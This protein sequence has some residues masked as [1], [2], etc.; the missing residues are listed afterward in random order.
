MDREP[1]S[2]IIDKKGKAQPNLGDEAMVARSNN[3]TEAP[4]E[5][6]TDADK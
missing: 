4:Q 6:K 1:G 5:V 3:Q 2:F